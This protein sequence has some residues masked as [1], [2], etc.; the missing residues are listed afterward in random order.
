MD[1]TRVLRCLAC[2]LSL[3]L[4]LTA[5]VYASDAPLLEMLRRKQVLTQPEYERLR[6][7]ELTPVQRTGLIDL[8]REKEVLTGEEARSLAQPT[9]AVVTAEPRQLA[10]A[11]PPQLGYDEGFFIR[12]AEGNFALRFT[13]RVASNFLF[14]EPGTTQTNTQ[15]IDRARL[16]VDAT[17]YKYFRM[18]LEND[19][20]F[21]SGLRDAFVAVT[22]MPEANLEVGQFKTPF[23]YEELLSKKYQDFVERAAVVTN[24]VNPA[25]DIGVMLYGQFA[26]KLL[27]YQLA[28]MNGSGQNRSDNNND[29]DL[30]ARLV[31]APLVNGGLP[32]LRTLNVGAAVTYGDQ[33]GE[34]ITSGKSTTSSISG[35]TETGFTFSPAVTRHGERL[36]WGLHGA[37]LDGP[38][39]VSSEYIQTDEARDGLGTEGSDL[40]G[41]H[42]DGAYVGGT[43]LITGEAKPF[44]ARLRPAQPLWDLTS[45]G[46]G[47]WEAAL[48]YEYFKLRHGPGIGADGEVDAELDSRYDA[49]VA[50]LNWYPNEFL[51]FSINYLY[52]NFDHQGKGHSPNPD[53][54]SNNAVL[55]RAQLEF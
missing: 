8:L 31:V 45:P 52:G 44:N 17:V 3:T 39:S 55:G 54:H 38:F 32:H 20:A 46:W 12:S 41:L 33:S 40:P 36:R 22:P 15:T 13:G 10:P 27:Q 2:G 34:T 48:R 18:R 11:A 30:V 37:W 25:R 16:G 9:P 47:A 19:F 4:L 42:T 29:K 43:W 6:G 23:S 26:N 49:V 21:S 50:G 24:A 35:A 1:R 7:S 14:F 51:R 53:K 5:Q 28:G